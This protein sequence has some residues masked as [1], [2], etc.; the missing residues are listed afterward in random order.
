MT[1]TMMALSRDRS[2]LRGLLLLSLTTVGTFPL[3]SANAQSDKNAPRGKVDLLSSVEDVVPGKPFDVGVR[4]KMAEGWHIYWINP[5]E[6]GMAPRAKWAL[7]NGF[8]AGELQ[9]PVP[10][11]HV[12][13]GD[14]VTNI[15]EDEAVLPVSITPPA[16]ISEKKI[17]LQAE[18]RYLICRESCL[19]ETAKVQLELPV[20]ASTAEIRD[21]NKDVFV[22]ARRALP[23][24]TSK[25]LSVKGD[26][27]PSTPGANQKLEV[28]LHLQINEGFHIQSHQPLNESFVKCDVLMEPTKG[29]VF[30][31]PVF[32]AGQ[33][34]PVKVLGQISEYSGK[35][36]VTIPA[37]SLEEPPVAPVRY[38]GLVLYQA[39]NEQG[40]CFPPDALSFS[41]LAGQP[42]T[43]ANDGRG[44]PT[45]SE[46]WPAADS[47]DERVATHEKSTA[48]SVPPTTP[49]AAQTKSAEPV[50]EQA[51][52]LEDEGAE[53]VAGSDNP[54][55]LLGW[56]MFAFLGGLLLNIMPC[57]LPVIS[58][59]VL[60][61]VQQ[62]D[63]APGRVVRLGMTFV[64]GIMVSF[65][66]M[67]LIVIILKS[68]GQQLGWGFQFQS[69]LFIVIMA[70]LMFLFGLSLFGV[71]EITLPGSASTKLASAESHE[72]Y[73]GAFVKGLLGTILATPCTAPYLGPAL[74]WAFTASAVELLAVFSAVGLGMSS[75]FILLSMQPKWVRFLPRPGVWMEYFKQFMGFLLMG[76]VAWLMY[77]L[78]HQIGPD[79]LVWMGVLLIFLGIGAWLIGKQTP[80]TSP[81]KRLA[82]WCTAL[83]LVFVGWS[84]SFG[85]ERSSID[86]LRA[87]YRRTVHGNC[88]L[89]IPT[90][91][92]WNTEIPW[93]HWSKG[94]AEQLSNDGY[95]VY[96]DYTATWCATCLANKNATLESKDVRA[97]MADLCVVPLKADFTDNNP[98]ILAELRKFG[99]SGVPLNVIYPAGKPEKPLVLPEQLVGRSKLVL[100]K[101]EV[102][103]SSQECRAV[104][105]NPSGVP[106]A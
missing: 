71:F 30:E 90:Q 4:F 72:G 23:K 26:A 42:T 35:V 11:R 10:R 94:L 92:Q 38:A 50:V 18:V 85:R 6:A 2:L 103:G 106:G 29:V 79:G 16:A 53:E 59:K 33:L 47:P 77:P 102:A 83:A 99:R 8:S 87:E 36:T 5:G 1:Q 74:G 93:Q 60:S 73:T 65:I 96:V 98:D 69:P 32:P 34:R 63:E 41:F 9:F 15:L 70:S 7:P 97:K 3:S 75:P 105:A 12:A 17:S 22:S 104:S 51:T 66:V 91:D 21:A 62:A 86:H 57:V 54:K 100:R 13:P 88:G 20:A 61:F 44:T 101:L 56:L 27:N 37:E 25:Y 52:Q 46:S 64:A 48:A 89:T 95:T 43:S 67:A 45:P 31:N 19:L 80:L 14:I 49:V 76:T 24:S 82:G 78:G 39:C 28:A 84:A 55:T 40:T 68:A 58:I 81:G